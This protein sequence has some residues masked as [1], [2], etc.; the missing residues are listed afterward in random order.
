MDVFVMRFPRGA[1]GRAL[2]MGDAQHA[3]WHCGNA[4]RDHGS[5]HEYMHRTEPVEGRRHA[6]VGVS[7]LGHHRYGIK[8]NF[9]ALTLRSVLSHT[10]AKA[11]A[12]VGD[13]MWSLSI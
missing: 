7:Y 1:H 5:A 2:Q 11:N 9:W 6:L 10:I 8:V 3:Y 4:Y 12:A 13:Y